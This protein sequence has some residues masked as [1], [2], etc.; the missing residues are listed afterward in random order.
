LPRLHP[1]IQR[2]ALFALCNPIRPESADEIGCLLD[3]GVGVL[4]LP[5]F[6]ITLEAEKF[7]RM[8]DGRATPVLLVETKESAAVMFDLCRI[9]GSTILRRLISCALASSDS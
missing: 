4:M 1:A 2:A 7:I 9:S 8:V 3:S 6:K 5:Y